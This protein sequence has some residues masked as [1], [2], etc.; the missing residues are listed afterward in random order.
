MTAYSFRG[1]LHYH[2]SGG[3]W[4]QPGRQDPGEVAKSC[5]S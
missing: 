1:L 2:Q 3:A 5:P 4:K